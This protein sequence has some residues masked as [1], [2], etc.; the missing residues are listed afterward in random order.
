MQ[1]VASCSG[2]VGELFLEH[3]VRAGHVSVVR[4]DDG[5]VVMGSGILYCLRG[6]ALVGSIWQLVWQQHIIGRHFDGNGVAPA[7]LRRRSFQTVDWL[8]GRLQVEVAPV[9]VDAADGSA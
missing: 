7:G 5:F 8:P 6:V 2:E 1:S 9:A 4:A 3:L